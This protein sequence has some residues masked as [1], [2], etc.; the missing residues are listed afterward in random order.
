MPIPVPATFCRS[1]CWIQHSNGTNRVG[2]RGTFLAPRRPGG[3]SAL[4]F[5]MNTPLRDLIAAK[6]HVR[7]VLELRPI[8]GSPRWR[9]HI[10]STFDRGPRF[11]IGTTDTEAKELIIEHRF[12]NISLARDQWAKTDRRVDA[13]SVSEKCRD[14]VRPSLVRAIEKCR[15]AD[16][17]HCVSQEGEAIEVTGCSKIEICQNGHGFSVDALRG[18]GWYGAGF[19][20][21]V[22]V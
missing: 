16:R 17:F 15:L 6:R 1:H 21:P 19:W 2:R 9:Y 22:L 4:L 11:V 14:E 20:I 10:E 13:I 7:A 3:E 18:G 8:A 5:K 12:G